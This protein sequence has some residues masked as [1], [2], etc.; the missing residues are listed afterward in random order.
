[1][2]S[3][4][5]MGTCWGDGMGEHRLIRKDRQGTQGA[6]ITLCARE[7]LGCT[8]LCLGMGEGLRVLCLVRV[9]ARAGTGDIILGVCCRPPDQKDEA[10]EAVYGHIEAA[11]PSQGLVLM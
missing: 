1:M 2:H 9:T 6:G 3:Q 11:S 5:L 4:D 8:E 10:D 7:P